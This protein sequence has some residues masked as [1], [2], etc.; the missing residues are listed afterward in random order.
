MQELPDSLNQV[1]T[2]IVNSLVVFA[3]FWAMFRLV[4]PLGDVFARLYLRICTVAKRTGQVMSLKKARRNV[5]KTAKNEDTKAKP[6]PG[7][8]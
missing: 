6:A 4:D 5:T 7:P 1:M 2:S 3:V 8:T